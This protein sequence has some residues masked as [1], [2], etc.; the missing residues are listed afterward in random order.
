[1]RVGRNT[2]YI[3]KNIGKIKSHLNSLQIKR[4]ENDLRLQSS[5]KRMYMRNMFGYIMLCERKSQDFFIIL[6]G[7][8]KENFIIPSP[9][10]PEVS[11]GLHKRS[12]YYG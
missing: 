9:I 8:V 6:N 1:M 11:A 7:I 2:G 5:T 3:Y 10:T 12:V 4:G